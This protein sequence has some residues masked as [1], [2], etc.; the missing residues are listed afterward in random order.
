[1]KFR[2]N[3]ASRRGS[4][5]IMVAVMLATLFAMAAFSID[6]A[7][8]Q[9]AQAELQ[10]ASDA[11]AK[12]AARELAL[13]DGDST[14]AIAAG[15]KFAGLNEV[16]G[17]PLTL[18]SADF[19]FGQAHPAMGGK[20]IFAAGDQP[21]S[22]VRVSAEKSDSAPSGSVRLFFGPF[23]GAASFSPQLTS[24]AAYPTNEIVLAID[25][26]H[27]MAFDGSGVDWVYPSGVPS[28]DAD[29]DGYFPGDD[30]DDALMTPPHAIRS[31]WASL[32]AAVDRFLTILDGS[33][34]PPEVGAVTWAS[35]LGTDTYEYSLSHETVAATTLETSI[36][37]NY[38]AIRNALTNRGSVKMHGGTDIAAGI[39]LGVSLLA[40]RNT[41]A[42]KTIILLTDGQQTAGRP[43]I[44]AAY[45]AH[46]AGIVVHVVTFLQ[47]D[48]S[49]MAAVATATGGR[50]IHAADEDELI[51]AFEELA[52][53]LPVS[54]I[55]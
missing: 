54:L 5:V 29:G 20:W 52:R 47:G 23:L 35:Y 43:A 10:A 4:M 53:L 26:S 1:M 37:R 55:D 15:K 2:P 3:R 17:K 18:T 33:I 46:A 19:E 12:A 51:E 42:K 14:A 50:H 44:D 41:P 32:R 6:V 22:A 45:D 25:R 24:T 7:Y 40:N 28:Y 30:G 21:Y 11:A 34:L 38:S 31:R 36:G 9:M 49:A 8:M 48:Q 27:S 13:T 39:D 16:A